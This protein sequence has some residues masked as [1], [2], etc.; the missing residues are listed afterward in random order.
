M[1]LEYK[2]NVV[3]DGLNGAKQMDKSLPTLGLNIIK[4]GYGHGIARAVNIRTKLIT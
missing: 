2:M 3:K 4:G 1:A